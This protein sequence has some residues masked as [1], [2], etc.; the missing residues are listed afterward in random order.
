[1]EKI[2]KNYGSD[3][4]K[5]ANKDLRDTLVQ[6]VNHNMSEILPKINT[7]VQLVYGEHDLVAPLENGKIA[8]SLIP[9]SELTD[10]V[11]KRKSFLFGYLKRSNY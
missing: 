1:M 9:D 8:D 3:D 10:S 5:N 7:H 11:V 2:K 6:A 4:Y